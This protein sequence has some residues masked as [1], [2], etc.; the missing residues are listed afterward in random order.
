MSKLV[1]A[2]S[3]FLSR[4]TSTKQ[5]KKEIEESLLLSQEEFASLTE[6]EQEDYVNQL[7]E[8]KKETLKSYNARNEES[9]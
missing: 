3:E 4:D 7:M 2:A 8:L 5:S 1:E 6:E 9:C